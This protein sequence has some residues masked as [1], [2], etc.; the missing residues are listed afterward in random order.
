MAAAADQ[1]YYESLSKF[2]PLRKSEAVELRE[3]MLSGDQSA[4]NRLIESVLKLVYKLCKKYSCKRHPTEDIVGD[5][6]P[7]VIRAID[8]WEPSVGSLSTIVATYVLNALKKYIA[9]NT[10]DGIYVPHHTRR[11]LAKGEIGPCTNRRRRE[12][13]LAKE[14]MNITSISPVSQEGERLDMPDLDRETTFEYCLADLKRMLRRIPSIERKA[15]RLRYFRAKGKAIPGY[16]EIGNKLGL[17]ARQ[18]RILIKNI[19][20]RL[21]KDVECKY[22]GDKFIPGVH[23]KEYCSKECYRKSQLSPGQILNCERCQQSFLSQKGAVY[24]SDQC[25]Q[26]SKKERAHARLLLVRD[27]IETAKQDEGSSCIQASA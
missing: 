4:R 11:V 15:I 14:A 18:C 20:E 13:A 16:L 19:I 1:D 12:I 2:R 10:H 8:A 7:H 23:L 24:C 6:I 27:S 21:K 26:I 5:M 22:C 3:Q 17:D 9:Q 25:V